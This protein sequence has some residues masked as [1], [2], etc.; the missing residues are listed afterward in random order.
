MTM[1]VLPEQLRDLPLI[2]SVSGG[3]D[4]TAMML[5]V[6]EAGLPFRAVFADTGWEAPETYAYL[7]VLRAHIGPIDVVRALP[8]V[9]LEL[10]ME[11]TQFS[12]GSLVHYVP[13]VETPIVPVCFADL[14]HCSSAMAE[15]IAVYAR[16]A[17]RTQR[18][19]TRELKLEPLHAYHRSQSGLPPCALPRPKKRD[20][21]ADDEDAEEI[22]PEI[23][24]TLDHAV[25]TVSVTGVRRDES[26]KRKDAKEIEDDVAWGGW[27][28]R[29]LVAWAVADIIGL[30]HRHDVPVNVLYQRGHDRVGCYPCINAT[31][32]DLTLVAR[33]APWRIEQLRALE[34]RATELRLKRNAEWVPTAK[35]P[36]RY[37]NPKA[38][39]FQGR[40]AGLTGVA[41]GIDEVVSWARTSRGGRQLPLL[42]EPPDG[43][44]F[45]WGFCDPPSKETP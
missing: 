21:E 4:S 14:F 17:S 45:R 6:R 43:G 3:K 27:A 1:L 26:E 34:A 15:R 29:P 25:H 13:H 28:W 18:W 24:A 39:F 31:K 40:D 22:E 35:R 19:C 12:D 33:H 2:L 23:D 5:A 42:V 8:P 10:C 37:K 41:P 20:P 16:F 32:S 44:C 11:V 36:L 38:T 30:H 7:D 9:A